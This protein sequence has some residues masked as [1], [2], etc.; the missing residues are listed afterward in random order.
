MHVSVYSQMQARI[1]YIYA[2][3][4]GESDLLYETSTG[5]IQIVHAAIVYT[6]VVQYCIQG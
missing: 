4:V 6:C 3:E 5:F 2:I 1:W